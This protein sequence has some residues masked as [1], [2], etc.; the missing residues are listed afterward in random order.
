VFS[1]RTHPYRFDADD[2]VDWIARHLFT[3]GLMPSHGPIGQ[4]SDPFSLE[5]DWR[6]SG[7]HYARTAKA[8]LANYDRHAGGI[9]Q[10]MRA[11]YGQ[12]ARLGAGAGACSSWPPQASSATL[13]GARGGAATTA[14]G[15]SRG[16]ARGHV[17]S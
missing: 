7:E 11:V 13:A 5:E 10:T 16:K 8:W 17:A 3:G 14:C 15:R 6:W 2:P 1:H 4:F 12:D 9:A